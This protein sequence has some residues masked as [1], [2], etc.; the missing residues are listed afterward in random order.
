[1][2][3]SVRDPN[4]DEVILVVETEKDTHAQASTRWQLIWEWDG[5]VR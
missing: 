4:K 1:M 3:R 2:E 5:M